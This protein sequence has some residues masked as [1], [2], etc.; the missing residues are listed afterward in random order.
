[1]AEEGPR[2]VA[3]GHVTPDL[4][5][6]MYSGVVD[7]EIVRLAFIAAKLQDLQVFTADIGSAYI[8]AHTTTEKGLHHCWT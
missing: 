4:D 3:G 7:L 1:M 2:C 6:D 5:V 8:Q